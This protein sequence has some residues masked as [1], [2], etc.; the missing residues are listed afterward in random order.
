M[1][2]FTEAVRE[3]LAYMTYAPGAVHFGAHRTAGGPDL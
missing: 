1:D 2:E 3:G